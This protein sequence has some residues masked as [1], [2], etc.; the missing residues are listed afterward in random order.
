MRLKI[1]YL[2]TYTDRHGRQRIYYNRPGHK[3]I[4]LP[5][6]IGSPEFLAAYEKAKGSK[7]K[8][9]PKVIPDS[10]RDLLNHYYASPEFLNL[11]SSTQKDRRRVYEKQ[12]QWFDNPVRDMTRADAKECLGKFAHKPGAGN[13]FLKYFKTLW[14]FA[15]EIEMINSNPLARLKG[16]KPG[17]GFHSWEESEIQQ[18]EARHPI[19]SKARLAMALMLYTGQRR[20]DVVKMGWQNVIDD[21]INV[22]QQKTGTDLSIPIHPALWAV[23]DFIPKGQPTFLQT[24]WGKP[25]AV[26]GFGNWFRE[27]CN[28][29]GLPQ[30]SSHGLRKAM[31]RRLAEAG[32]SNQVIKSITGHSQD[33]EVSHYT[34]GA[35]QKKL[36]KQAIDQL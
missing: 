1:K 33:K 36:A 4:P 2:H 18:F 24:E 29:A 22:T 23:L 17:K 5:G 32:C 14:N 28:E 31:A 13:K 3:K 30:C 35:S 20:S 15:V 6:P 7:P 27:R 19:G 26:A 9:L 21:S 11:A 12:A 8:L 25:F 34:K 16:F 10:Y